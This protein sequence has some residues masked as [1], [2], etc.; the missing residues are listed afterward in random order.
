METITVHWTSSSLLQPS[1]F[2]SRHAMQN[3]LAFDAVATP[4]EGPVICLNNHLHERH[5]DAYTL[6]QSVKQWMR[7]IH[8]ISNE[9]CTA[10][11]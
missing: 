5:N 7:Q 6:I 2:S 8:K 1:S 11:V 4:D 9:V 3:H 10:T